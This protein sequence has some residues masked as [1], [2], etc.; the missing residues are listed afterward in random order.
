MEVVQ[1]SPSRI[2]R[3][4]IAALLAVTVVAMFMLAGTASAVTLT[5]TSCPLPGSNF[6][7]G[8]GNQQ[9]E[10]A[11]CPTAND[12]S[13]PF[14]DWQGVAADSRTLDFNA[15]PDGDPL[16]PGADSTFAG[17][18]KETDLTNWKISSPLMQVTPNKDNLFAAWEGLAKGASGNAP[19]FLYLALSREVNTG[20]THLE[21]ELNQ[22]PA[23][24]NWTNAVGQSVPCRTNGD[25]LISYEVASGGSP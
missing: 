6:Q 7:G 1:M 11:K 9:N 15:L 3:V 25:L 16:H 14:I 8:D 18:N 2:R 5:P 4:R 10:S 17:G 22:K 21:F 23:A 24:D 12:P 13:A 19:Q 20:D